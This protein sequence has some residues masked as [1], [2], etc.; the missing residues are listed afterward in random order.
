[1]IIAC[2]TMAIMP[3]IIL[4]FRFASKH[5]FPQENNFLRSKQD[6]IFM[7]DTKQPSRK[8]TEMNPNR[9]LNL[10][11]VESF[12]K[13]TDHHLVN[14]DHERDWLVFLHIQKT[15]GT[16]LDMGIVK[17]VMVSK[18]GTRKKGCTSFKVI[19]KVLSKFND[20]FINRTVKTTEHECKRPAEPVSWYIS[21][22]D[23]SFGWSCGLHSGLSDMQSCLLKRFPAQHRDSP[24]ENFHFITILRSPIKRY[25]S[26]WY[27]LTKNVDKNS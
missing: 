25:I 11:I 12:K 15:S 7:K 18:N 14:F 26:E 1:M 8:I 22:H 13:L 19:K 3:V 24:L 20:K 4:Q 17:H 2:Y 10:S 16:N 5:S 27:T 6:Q 21:W 23:R 9:Q